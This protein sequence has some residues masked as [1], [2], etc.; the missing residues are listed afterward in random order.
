MKSLF[1]FKHNVE[2]AWCVA[3]E[4]VREE[5]GSRCHRVRFLLNLVTSRFC[6]VKNLARTSRTRPSQP[7]RANHIAK[8]VRLKNRYLLVNIL[9]PES[10]EGSTKTKIPDVIAFNQAT[11]QALN[12]QALLKA[13]RAEIQFLFGDFGSGAISDS[14]SGR[15][16]TFKVP[17]MG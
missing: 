15:F 6:T 3:W 10:G 13:L 11:A 14:L 8:M 17:I 2:Y 16:C 5:E 1:L 9:Y 7:N 12:P 4:A